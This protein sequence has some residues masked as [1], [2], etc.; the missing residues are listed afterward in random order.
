VRPGSAPLRERLTPYERAQ[1]ERYHGTLLAELV[2]PGAVSAS[3]QENFVD[4]RLTVRKAWRDVYRHDRGGKLL[5]WTRH[6][7]AKPTE[8]TS[9]GL[10]VLEKDAKG[11]PVKARSVRSR[12]DL[13]YNLFAADRKP[14]RQVL[15]DEVVTCE[16]DGDTVRVKSREKVPPGK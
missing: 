12:L 5:G 10:I 7:G 9:D 6:D 13:P 2:L 14:L 11:R 4:Q 15:G 16:Y 3:F 8:F 1:L